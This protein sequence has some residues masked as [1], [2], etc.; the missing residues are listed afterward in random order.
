MAEG[1]LNFG[2]DMTEVT[3]DAV[4]PSIQDWAAT[5]VQA[6]IVTPVPREGYESNAKQPIVPFEPLTREIGVLPVADTEVREITPKYQQVIAK[7]VSQVKTPFDL[8]QRAEGLERPSAVYYGG[9]NRAV[10]NMEPGLDKA[11]IFSKSGR[12][13][14]R[15]QYDTTR[16]HYV[17]AGERAEHVGEAFRGLKRGEV[18][19]PKDLTFISEV[20]QE[21]ANGLAANLDNNFPG[22]D[23]EARIAGNSILAI[24]R[25]IHD[26]Q[27]D[28]QAHRQLVYA[29]VAYVRKQEALWRKKLQ[30]IYDFA[31]EK[32][33]TVGE[34]RDEVA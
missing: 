3:Y 34:S 4:Y 21:L 25:A 5:R 9:Q 27:V 24:G 29:G 6:G 7:W 26:G 14:V 17:I 32:G 13:A 33:F 19:T 8:I 20:L 23:F 15:R 10:K 31:A 1:Q 28:P 2:D 11:V 30:E 12:A 16:H 18:C 22:G